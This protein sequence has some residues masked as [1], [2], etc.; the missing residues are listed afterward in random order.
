MN[1]QKTHNTNNSDM[2]PVEY[3]KQHYENIEPYTP[4]KKWKGSHILNSILGAGVGFFPGLLAAAYTST[5]TKSKNAQ[6]GVLGGTMGV[7]AL[8]AS[9]ITY[10]Y[11]KSV[12]KYNSEIKPTHEID[13]DPTWSIYEDI[14]DL[15]RYDRGK[16]PLRNISDDLLA[17]NWGL[18][19]KSNA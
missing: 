11:N 5:K 8:L 10:K 1:T 7:G 2:L 6:L 16:D 19:R 9:L 3:Y 17:K 14:A 18:R 4:P 12:N 15:E 13:E